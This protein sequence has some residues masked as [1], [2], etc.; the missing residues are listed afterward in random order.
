VVPFLKFG[1]RLM[2]NNP[3]SVNFIRA[4][5]IIETAIFKKIDGDLAGL[6]KNSTEAIVSGM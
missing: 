1:S 2:V 6:I 3:F 5:L 4:L